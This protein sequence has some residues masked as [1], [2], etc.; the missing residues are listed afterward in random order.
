[1]D[2]LYGSSGQLGQRIPQISPGIDP[3]LLTGGG[4]ARQNGQRLSTLI[5]T[6]EQPVFSANGKRTGTKVG[7]MNWFS[8]GS[9]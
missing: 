8:F 5:R 7:V 9:D 1:M 2:L 6:K 4:A 3:E